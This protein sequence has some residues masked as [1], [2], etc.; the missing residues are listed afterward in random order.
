MANPVQIGLAVTSH[1]AAVLCTAVF[2]DVP[3]IPGGNG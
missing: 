2:D 1:N 3:V